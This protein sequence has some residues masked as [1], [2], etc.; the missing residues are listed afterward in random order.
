[1]RQDYVCDI[2]SEPCGLEEFKLPGDYKSFVHLCEFHQLILGEMIRFVYSSGK[3]LRSRKMTVDANRYR[4]KLTE[5]VETVY[6]KIEE[7][8]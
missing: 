7:E 6:E 8:V 3:S 2:C 4:I 5:E 1:M